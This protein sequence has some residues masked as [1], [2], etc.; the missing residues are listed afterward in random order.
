MVDRLPRVHF[1]SGP[2]TRRQ[3]TSCPKCRRSPPD[4]IHRNELTVVTDLNVR[5]ETVKPLE[6]N[7]GTNLRAGGPVRIP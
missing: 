7:T 2:P 6:E 5:A 3:E 4:A 1:L